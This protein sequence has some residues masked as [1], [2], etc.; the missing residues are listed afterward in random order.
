VVLSPDQSEGDVADIPFFPNPWIEEQRLRKAK[1][2]RIRQ[3]DEEQARREEERI[4]QVEEE[5]SQK[6]ARARQVG[7]NRSKVEEEHVEH[8]LGPRESRSNAQ[9]FQE[10]IYL[11]K[12][13][14][15]QQVSSSSTPEQSKQTPIQR[16]P[17]PN[18]SSTPTRLSL[19][20]KRFSAIFSI[21]GII[22]AGIGCI[23]AITGLISVGLRL[24]PAGVANIFSGLMIFFLAR[25]RK[26]SLSIIGIFVG[27]IAILSGIGLIIIAAN[28]PNA[29]INE[30][31]GGQGSGGVES[32]TV[33]LIAG[34][35]ILGSCAFSMIRGV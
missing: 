5:I 31:S 2:E 20:R 25:K 18:P 12:A 4:H 27:A 14:T 29:I 26:S 23:I 15:H 21:I 10:P 11:E 19:I 17:A 8:V 13:E 32:G 3:A 33:T 34:V 22:W 1:E 7:Q 6:E 9:L 16:P 30:V 28:F 35:I 24:F